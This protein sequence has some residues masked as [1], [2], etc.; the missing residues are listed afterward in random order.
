MIQSEF[1]G[2]IEGILC[3]FDEVICV[4]VGKSHQLLI[5]DPLLLFHEVY[6]SS[7]ECLRFRLLDPSLQL[8]VYSR[9]KS[10]PEFDS[11][12]RTTHPFFHHLLLAL[13]AEEV[14]AR[15]HHWLNAELEAYGAVVL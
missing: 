1:G 3:I 2:I 15:G 5:A 7:L 6:L 13:E 9:G 4:A 8:L 12:Q 10:N 14:I 11:A